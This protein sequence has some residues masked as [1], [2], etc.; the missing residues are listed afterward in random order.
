LVSVRFLHLIDRTNRII[1]LAEARSVLPPACIS[2]LASGVRRYSAQCPARSRFFTIVDRHLTDGT[3]LNVTN[4]PESFATASLGPE[5][6]Q[7]AMA[8]PVCGSGHD[9]STRAGQEMTTATV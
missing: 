1:A 5:E 9:G 2:R 3:H 4:H 7:P 6:I 8:Q